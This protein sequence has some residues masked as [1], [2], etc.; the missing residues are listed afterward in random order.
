MARVHD[1]G[2]GTAAAGAALAVACARP[3]AIEGID[4]SGWALREARHTHA[5]FGL[6][7]R[8]R[9]ASVPESLPR[10]RSGDALVLGWMANEL[11]QEARVRLLAFVAEAAD[12]GHPV[13]VLEPLARGVAPWWPTW[14]ATLAP[15]GLRDLELKVEAEL[16]DW[17]ARLDAASGL[18]HTTLGARVLAGPGGAGAQPPG[19]AAVSPARG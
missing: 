14:A 8:T 5:A 12:E 17:I 13:L 7:G 9:R 18:D 15:A 2:C 4:R 19:S 6:R 3:V 16:P 1:L 11:E 10:L